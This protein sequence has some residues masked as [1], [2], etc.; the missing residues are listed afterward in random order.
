MSDMV[1]YN[2]YGR[3]PFFC[4]YGSSKLG[5]KKKR[6]SVIVRRP[7]TLK[8]WTIDQIELLGRSQSST[9]LVL[10]SPLEE[11]EGSF[12]I[13]VAFAFQKV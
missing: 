8:R 6:F 13:S 12:L 10:L 4:T 5:S 3:I 7:A 9:G 2:W 11:L 1:M